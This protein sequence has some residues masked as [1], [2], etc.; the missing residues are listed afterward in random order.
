MVDLEKEAWISDES[1]SKTL[2]QI[3]LRLASLFWAA[4][5]W[6]KEAYS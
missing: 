3:E 6:G 4:Y 1:A 2:R 5:G